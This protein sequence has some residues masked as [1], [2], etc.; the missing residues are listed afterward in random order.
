MLRVCALLTLPRRVGRTRRISPR[1]EKPL[2]RKWQ[3]RFRYNEIGFHRN[4]KV[5]YKH[6]K[7]DCVPTFKFLCLLV[8]PSIYLDINKMRINSFS[9]VNE[10]SLQSRSAGWWRLL[11][12][13]QGWIQFIFV[14]DWWLPPAHQ[15]H[16]TMSSLQTLILNLWYPPLATNTKLY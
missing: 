11:I 1:L 12:L 13:A 2:W 3:T 8:L 5:I 15:S 14:Q 7:K 6:V 16:L 10:F 4:Y 9:G